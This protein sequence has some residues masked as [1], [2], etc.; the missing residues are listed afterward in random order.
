VIENSIDI[1]AIRELDGSRGPG[2]QAV[3]MSEYGLDLMLVNE[4]RSSP[5]DIT[6]G[7]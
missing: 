7:Y 4:Q 3:D 1:L 5:G 2:N 6:I